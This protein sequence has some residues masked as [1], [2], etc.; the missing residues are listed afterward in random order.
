MTDQQ[1]LGLFATLCSNRELCA[2]V[3]S[4]GGLTRRFKLM[5]KDVRFFPLDMQGDLRVALEDAV[6]MALKQ[7]SNLRRL[8]WTVSGLV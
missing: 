5:P 7:M 8:E 3:H 6:Q 4:L 2:M 1:L